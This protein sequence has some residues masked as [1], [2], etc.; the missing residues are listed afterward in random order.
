MSSLDSQ[1]D[2]SGGYVSASAAGAVKDSEQGKVNVTLSS[3][4]WFSSAASSGSF[5]S[6]LFGNKL[7][8]K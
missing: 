2:S 7:K 6:L 3:V 4:V 1:G 8:E 5:T